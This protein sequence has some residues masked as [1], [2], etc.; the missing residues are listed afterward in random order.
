MERYDEYKDSGIEWV[1][2]IP[3][4]W[5]TCRIS[6]MYD[7][8]NEKVSDI[9]YPPLSVTMQGIVP[10]L[11]TAAK[12]LDGDNRKLVKA[13]DFAINSRSD[14][15]GSCGI[16]PSDGSVSLITNVLK[17]IDNS[18]MDG[19]YYERLY[20]TEGFADE[21][22]RWGNGI[23]DDLW[24][25]NWSKMKNITIPVPTLKEQIAIADYLDCEI[26]QIDELIADQEKSIGL[27][28]EYRKAVI[29]EAVTKGLD[30]DAPMKDSGIDWIGKIPAEWTVKRLRYIGSCQNGISA[31]AERFGEGFPFVSYGNVYNSEVLA[32]PSSTS[33]MNA[34]EEERKRF[35]V[36]EGDVFF[37][38]T[39]ETVDEIGIASVCGCTIPDAVFAGFLIR[40]RFKSEILSVGFSKYFFRSEHH[41]AY[42]S[43]EMNLV[44]R[45]SLG[46]DLLKN[47][48]ILIP[49]FSDQHE[50]TTY[51]DAK[52]AEIDSLIWDKQKLIT[53]LKEYRKSLIFEAVTGKFKVPEVA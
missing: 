4:G 15:R 20:K 37:T 33:L 24:S 11:D 48:Q 35:S 16:S 28:E 5:L 6:N 29:S 8:R 3:A 34:T 44:T 50:I 30:P 13:G 31:G 53:K 47:L 12:S 2:E 43:K 1:G 18:C 17:P 36:R 19:R 14:R 21:Y 22:Y 26:S 27:L 32:V 10:Q 52:T 45:A 46:Q 38:R 9:D 7:Q 23:V 25:T 40:V 51:L 41:R 42:F 39:S 49:P